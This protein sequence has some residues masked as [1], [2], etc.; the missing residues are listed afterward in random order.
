MSSDGLRLLTVLF[1]SE[2]KINQGIVGYYIWR[3]CH[4]SEKGC[5]EEAKRSYEEGLARFPDSLALQSGMGKN[6]V[7]TR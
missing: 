4:L 7:R 1:I 2:E 5:F 3:G 6:F